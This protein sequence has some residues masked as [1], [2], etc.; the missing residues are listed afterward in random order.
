MFKRILIGVDDGE[1]A[2]VAVSF[3]SALAERFGSAVHL[4]H[5][6]EFTMGSR[7]VPLRTDQEATDLV[8]RAAEPFR[9][10]GV[11]V[12]GSV[13]RACPRDVPERLADAAGEFAAD[14]IVLGSERRRRFRALRSH[15]VRERTIRLTAVPVIAA[16]AP[17]SL[18]VDGRFSVPE[19]TG[20]HPSDSIAT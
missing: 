17:L 10:L 4:V 7:G 19:P 11:A 1:A 8:L 18:P 14:V 5:V 20:P 13:R 3:A 6:N 16:P 9:T 2:D 12:S 15:H